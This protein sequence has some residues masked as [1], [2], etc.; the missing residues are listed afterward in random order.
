M[1]IN[2]VPVEAYRQAGSQSAKKDQAGS[3][4]KFDLKKAQEAEKIVLTGQKSGETGAI[5][6]ESSP[7]VLSNILT[8]DENAALVK[9]FARFGDSAESNQIYGRNACTHGS[10]ITGLKVDLTG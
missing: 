3:Q 9:S 2:T 5:R 10:S 1:K 7:S 4:E 8:A 6:V